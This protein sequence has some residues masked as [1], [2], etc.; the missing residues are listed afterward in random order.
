MFINEQYGFCLNLN[1]NYWDEVMG[2]IPF[3]T[4]NGDFTDYLYSQ[5]A[6]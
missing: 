6:F 1:G 2:E 4:D 5:L 3:F